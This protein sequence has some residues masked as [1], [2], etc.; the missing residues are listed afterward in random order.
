MMVTIIATVVMMREPTVMSKPP[1]SYLYDH[2]V[3]HYDGD[4][5][6]NSGDDG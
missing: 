6:Y 3:F 4:N 1:V 2:D 5:D